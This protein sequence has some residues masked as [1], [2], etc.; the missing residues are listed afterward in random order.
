M[1]STKDLDGATHFYERG[2]IF[3]F[4]RIDGDRLFFHDESEWIEHTFGR[5]VNHDKWLKKNLSKLKK[6][7]PCANR[8]NQRRG[9][10]E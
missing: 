8:A 7:K 1:D 4:Y 9:I 3:W 5:D 2:G 10:Y 6:V